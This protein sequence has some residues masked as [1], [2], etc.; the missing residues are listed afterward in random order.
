[1]TTPVPSG[2]RVRAYECDSLGHVNNSVYLQYL[3]QTTH[4]VLGGSSANEIFLFPRALSIEYQAPARDG[5]ELKI[6]LW[7]LEGDEAQ[8]TLAYKITRIGDDAPV[9][10]AR[11]EWEWRDRVSD[12]RQPFLEQNPSLPISEIPSPLKPFIV[13]RE[14]EA[15][16]FHW[17][18]RARRYELDA[19]NRVAVSAYTNWLEEATYDYAAR[20]GWD[21]DKMRAEDFIVLQYRRDTEFFDAAQ[22]G[23]E[24]EIVSRLIVVQRV[25]GMWRHEMFRAGMNEL[26]LRDYSTGVFLDWSGRP[27]LPPQA[28]MDALVRGE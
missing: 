8:Y 6:E 18:H 11:I 21:M 22:Y 28:M 24:I 17:R 1:M 15:R 19:S 2:V 23:D 25:R 10:A 14:N 5:D 26:I 16:P 27:R 9:I 3:H 7:R 12:A 4:E 20:V 13:P